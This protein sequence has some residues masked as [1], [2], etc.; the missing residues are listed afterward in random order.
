VA[1]AKK[2]GGGSRADAV[3]RV[4]DERVGS[5]WGEAEGVEGPG[6][7]DVKVKK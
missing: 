1:G 5:G 2:S 3:E 6:R 4:R 7:G